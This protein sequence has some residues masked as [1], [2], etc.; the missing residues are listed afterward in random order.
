M[1]RPRV[2]LNAAGVRA[3]LTSPGVQSELEGRM[4]PVLA[5][6]Q[7]SAPEKSGA[8]K[9]SLRLWAEVHRGR[10]ARVAVHV[11]SD[12]DHAL[13][14]EG[15]HGTLSRAFDAVGGSS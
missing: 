12:A 9:A 4:A 6:A 10:S 2:V 15:S 8:Y 3:L 7:A 13:Q 11:G 14:V 1:A 5:A